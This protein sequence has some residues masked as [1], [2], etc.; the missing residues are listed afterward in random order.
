MTNIKN[1]IDRNAIIP[2]IWKDGGYPV[3]VDIMGT[4]HVRFLKKFIKDFELK[5][6][7]LQFETVRT[8]SLKKAQAKEMPG[9]MKMMERSILKKRDWYGGIIGPHFHFD[10]GIYLLNDDQW[11]SYT[12]GI[13]KILINKLQKV[14]EIPFRPGA[15]IAEVMLKLDAPEFSGF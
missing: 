1:Y 13:K 10:S 11:H 14:Q 5:P 9:K 3:P 8:R 2:I 12:M 4:T 6:V 15:A 7:R